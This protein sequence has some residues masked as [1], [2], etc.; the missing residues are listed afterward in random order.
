MWT[1]STE[2]DDC[3]WSY[4]VAG[5]AR[6]VETIRRTMARALDRLARG[7]DRLADTV[8]STTAGESEPVPSWLA[9]AEDE[10]ATRP[11]LDLVPGWARCTS[12]TPMRL[13]RCRSA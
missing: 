11:V 3:A 6:E 8:A 2:H 5:L 4:A 1:V 12:A 10:H 13:G 7:R 9:L